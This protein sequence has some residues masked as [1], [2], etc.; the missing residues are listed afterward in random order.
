MSNLTDAIRYWVGATV[1]PRQVIIE[2][3]RRPNKVAVA[4]WVNVIFAALY[5]ITA[6]IYYAIG[7]LPA[8]EPWMPIAEERYY[9]YQ[10]FWTIPWG[11]I[12]WI[13]FS[14]AAHLL[15]IAGRENP[16][17]YI[18]EDALVVCG[19]G[20]VVPNAILM[21][22]T[23]TILVPLF[24]VFWPAW[25]ETLRLMVLPVAWQ[26]VLVGVGLRETHEVG[27]VRGL[28]IGLITVMVFFASFLAYMR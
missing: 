11:L 8:V 9:L 12:T 2:L 15:A 16:R 27:W 28:G 19:L 13:A 5:A 7:R 22:I 17:A 23:E 24:G 26:I 3:K 4:V 25:I 14:G 1:K 18:Y 21:W 10:I 20:W 6:L